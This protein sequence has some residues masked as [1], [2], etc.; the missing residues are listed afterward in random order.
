M[1]RRE[2]LLSDGIWVATTQ[3]LAA[4]GQLLGIRLLTETL[5]PDVFGITNLLIGVVAL[6]SSGIANPTM[7]AM[8]RYYPEY[9]H[10]GQGGLVR[11]VAR[12]QLSRLLLWLV[13][14]IAGA[15]VAAMWFGWATTIQL[16]LIALLV[17]VDMARMQGMALLNAV[18]S[19]RVYGYWSLLE[20]W[21]RPL[22]AFSLVQYF[23]VSVEAVLSGFLLASLLVW[24]VMRRNLPVEEHMGTSHQA[25]SELAKHVWKYTL[26]LLPLGLIGWVTGMADRYLIATW[27]T[28]ADVGLYVAIYALASRPMLMLGS[29]VETTLRPAYQQALAKNDI[30]EAN[31]YL[32]RWFLLLAA[33]CSMAIFIALLAHEYIAAL[34]LGEAYRGV[35]YFLPWIVAGYSLLVISH[36]TTRICYAHGNTDYVLQIE[37]L[38]A[39]SAVVLGYFLIA[40]YG[41]MGAVYAIPIYFGI[42]LM[43]S[44]RYAWPLLRQTQLSRASTA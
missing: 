1:P 26:P 14:V 18:R 12:H 19:H 16:V 38:G 32:K 11:S 40:S 31:G 34:L 2:N 22:A 3:A 6:L 15:V 23:G 30:G 20:A 25:I 42:Q 39:I 24:F 5:P 28:P 29:I 27:L 7:Q 44:I 9:H 13:P 37:I 41:L 43:A 36:I 4:V 10:T 8:L 35:S 21:C 17:I 33:G